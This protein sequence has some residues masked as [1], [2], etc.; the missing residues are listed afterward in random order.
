MCQ[1]LAHAVYFESYH[2][3]IQARQKRM[4]F[5]R[6][7]LYEVEPDWRKKAVVL[8]GPVENTQRK[9][10]SVRLQENKNKEKTAILQITYIRFK[11]DEMK[12]TNIKSIKLTMTFYPKH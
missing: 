6:F 1:C 11:T 7:T 10:N 3:S 5:P 9:Y 2:F 12:E 8:N 4:I